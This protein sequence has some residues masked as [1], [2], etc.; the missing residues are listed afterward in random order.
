MPASTWNLRFGLRYLWKSGVGRVRSCIRCFFRLSFPCP[1]QG[2]PG[3]L[4]VR[5][6]QV[7][8]TV[9][10]LAMGRHTQWF[11]CLRHHCAGLPEWRFLRL[12]LANQASASE[13]RFPARVGHRIHTVNLQGVTGT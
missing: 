6:G 12:I 1:C 8:R 13:R 3:C 7:S 9:S 10:L 5:S 11:F 4:P 2:V